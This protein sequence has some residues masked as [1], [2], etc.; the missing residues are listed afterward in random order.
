MLTPLPQIQTTQ[1]FTLI[2]KS[3]QEIRNTNEYFFLKNIIPSILKYIP[4]KYFREGN[5]F[6]DP[7]SNYIQDLSLL[8]Q[9]S[10]TKT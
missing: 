3:K 8:K 9:L 1:N 2:N 10:I 7:P 5:I 6:G 4:N